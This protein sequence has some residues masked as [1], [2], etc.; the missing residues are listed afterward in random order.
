[1]DEDKRIDSDQKNVVELNNK[2]NTQKLYDKIRS[3]RPTYPCFIVPGIIQYREKMNEDISEYIQKSK[4]GVPKDSKKNY[5]EG[6]SENYFLRILESWF[7][8]KIYKDVGLYSFN[9]N[10]IFVPDILLYDETNNFHLAIEI[11]EPYSYKENRPIHYISDDYES[12][13]WSTILDSDDSFITYDRK[14]FGIKDIYSRTN[15]FSKNHWFLVRFSE[16]QVV[17]TPESCCNFI[18]KK[19]SKYLNHTITNINYSGLPDLEADEMWTFEEANQMAIKKY[20]DCY[21]Q[22]INMK[23]TSVVSQSYKEYYKKAKKF[24][25]E[26]LPF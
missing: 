20:R 19:I 14:T 18:V 16:Y 15:E 22:S 7:P 2:Q 8:N 10:T 4:I 25:Q 13:H 21:L 1:M 11:E 24:T 12:N 9:L 26:I 3:P 17:R 6:I 23:T 5:T